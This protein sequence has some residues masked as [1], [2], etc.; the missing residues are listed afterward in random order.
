MKPTLPRLDIFAVNYCNF[1]CA[2]CL[3]CCRQQNKHK[4]YQAEDYLPALQK[5]LTYAD[6]KL[7]HIA[8][9]EPTLHSNL[10]DFTTK[11]R[12]VL[13][14]TT[15]LEIIS[16]GWWMPDE[17]KFGNIWSKI[18]KLGQGIHPQLLERLPLV[19]WGLSGCGW[20][21]QLKF[22]RLR[23]RSVAPCG[24]GILLRRIR[25]SGAGNLGR[26]G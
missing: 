1:T 19:P 20:R 3:A 26:Q 6:I 2:N 21:L 24:G 10:E 22:R 9:G 23:C 5:L 16:N 4:E 15:Q 13:K 17:D 12:K 11:I 25:L 8:G 18:D 7:F 14:P